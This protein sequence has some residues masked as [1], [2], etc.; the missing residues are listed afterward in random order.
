MRRPVEAREKSRRCF[1][2]W[3]SMVFP[4]L[5]LRDSAPADECRARKGRLICGHRANSQNQCFIQ[6]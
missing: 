5:W 4:S 2:G 3:P 6:L 1:C